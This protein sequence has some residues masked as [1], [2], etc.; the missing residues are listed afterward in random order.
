MLLFGSARQKS[1]NDFKIFHIF[2]IEAIFSL[3]RF[4]HN[5]LHLLIIRFCAITQ[6]QYSNK[7]I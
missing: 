2:I 5:S 1:M 3:S 4:D 7:T 6:F